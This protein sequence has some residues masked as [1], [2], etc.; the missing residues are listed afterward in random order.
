MCHNKSCI[1]GILHLSATVNSCHQQK[2]IKKTGDQ[3]KKHQWEAEQG[4]QE[5]ILSGN[6]LLSALPIAP[7]PEIS[8]QKNGTHDFPNTETLL[9]TG[10]VGTTTMRIERLK[11]RDAKK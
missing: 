6:S 1:L 8:E 4:L 11:L 10:L 3:P 2:T 7:D 9:K 5:R